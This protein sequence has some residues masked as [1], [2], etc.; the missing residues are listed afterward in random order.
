MTWFWRWEKMD[1]S[2]DSVN[3]SNFSDSC[4]VFTYVFNYVCRGKKNKMLD[5][6]SS[7]VSPAGNVNLLASS[8][9]AF[10]II[11]LCGILTYVTQRENF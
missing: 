3:M 4:P 6:H 7:W 11:I 2:V 10:G 9:A 8:L 5:L 1:S